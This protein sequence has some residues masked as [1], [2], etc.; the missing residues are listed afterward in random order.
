MEWA[1]PVVSLFE[2]LAV[3]ERTA[4]TDGTECCVT[5][6]GLFSVPILDLKT[7]LYGSL[8]PLHILLSV[9]GKQGPKQFFLAFLR[10]VLTANDS[11]AGFQAALRQPGAQAEG[12]FL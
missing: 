11:E 4:E 6:Q 9:T 5:A 8:M 3:N 10:F 1:S 2:T 12:S 7:L